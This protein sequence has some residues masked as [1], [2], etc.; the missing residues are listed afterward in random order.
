MNDDTPTADD[1]PDGAH[2][3]ARYVLGGGPLGTA[4]ARRLRAAGREVPVIDVSADADGASGF[5]GSPVDARLLDEAGVAD[6]STV[7][8]ATQSDRRNLLIAQLVSARFDVPD[9]VVLV[10]APDRLD[11]FAD[12]GHDPVCA[13]SVLS[14]ALATSV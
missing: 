3:S 2:G 14:D 7:V 12:A 8:V 1:P 11:A 13:T 5:Q 6:A 9:V 10:N 4:V